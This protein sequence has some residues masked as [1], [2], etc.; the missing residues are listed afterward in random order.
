MISEEVRQKFFDYWK[1]APRN[2]KDIPSVSLVPE[3]NSTLLFVNSGMFPLAPYLAG[4][5]HPMGTRLCDI[6]RCLRTKYDEMIEVGDNR[7]TLMFEMMGNWSLGDYFKEKQIPWV[8][9]LYVKVFSLDPTRLYVSVWGGDDK[10]PRDDESIALWK[11]AFRKIG[12]IDAEFSENIEDIPFSLEAGKTHKTR[13]FPYTAVGKGWWQ[14]GEAPG[15]LGGT[16]SEMFYD[17][18]KIERKQEKYHINDDSGR[19]VEIGNSVFMEYKLDDQMK[20]QKLPQKNVDFGGGFERLVMAIQ[21][22]TDIFETDIYKSILDKI[23]Q[24]SGKKYKAGEDEEL[25]ENEY[26]AAFRVIADHG[27]AAT[28]ILA[29][30]VTPSNKDHGYILRR[31][32]RRLVRYGKKLGLD[33]NFTSAIGRSVIDRMKG[34]Y[35]HL[36]MHRDKIV[37]ELNKEETKFRQTLDKG[38]KELE[39]MKDVSKDA[40]GTK[41]LDGKKAFYLYESFGFPLEMVLDELGADE[42]T[43]TAIEKEFK[44]IEQSHREKSRA[45]AEKKFKGGL[46]GHADV[47]IRYHT[48]THL[49]L[50]A[51]QKILGHEIHQ[52]GSNITDERLRFDFNWPKPLTKEELEKVETLLNR[53]ISSELEIKVETMSKE[54]AKKMGA[55]C[56]FW[57]RYPE[58][59][60]VYTIFGPK[61]KEVVS[62]ELCG[63]PHVKSLAELKSAG[64][65][66][67]IKEEASSAGVR[68][69]K[70]VLK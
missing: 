17:F 62:K 45:G 8:L 3:E 22:K 69:I 57:E 27:R 48:A 67:I 38:L 59:V 52:Q 7:H 60:S 4:Q 65:F 5:S 42:K 28:F 31:F 46:A 2:H 56:T 10:I 30:G 32:I 40:K 41:G 21:N 1:S 9:E 13:I 68:R 33:E 50:S 6:Q 54:E 12:G 29:D 11:Q 25:N 39:K 24:L 64:K 23:E 18:G 63:G 55:E 66:K 34:V 15:E 44:A 20:W 37:A 61:T 70:A 16:T 49:L 35:P 36:E 26:T 47:H 53:W 51:L 43:A 58:K 14:R 19:F